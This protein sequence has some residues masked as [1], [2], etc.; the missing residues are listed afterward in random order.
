[1]GFGYHNLY[2]VIFLTFL[3]KYL[4]VMSGTKNPAEIIVKLSRQLQFISVF[5]LI[6][7]YWTFFSE[8]TGDLVMKPITNG[9][10]HDN[11]LTKLIGYASCVIYLAYVNSH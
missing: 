7:K 1:M 6:L 3:D 9:I 5:P 4:F 2:Q 10:A 11:N 8:T